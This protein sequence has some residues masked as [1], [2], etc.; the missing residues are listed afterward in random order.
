MAAAE[1]PPLAEVAWRMRALETTVG[2]LDA[3]T[4]ESLAALSA[5]VASLAFVRVDLYESEKAAFG[6]DLAALHRELDEVRTLVKM[7][8][9]GI[10]S[11]LFGG[12]ATVLIAIARGG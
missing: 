6:R 8:L 4:S 1:D 2:K 5:Q 10:V 12:V 11:M 7:A 9:G 3:R